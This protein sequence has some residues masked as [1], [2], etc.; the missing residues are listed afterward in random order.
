MKTKHIII[1][2]AFA[3]SAITVAPAS[4]AALSAPLPKFQ[5]Q[6]QLR[7]QLPNAKTSPTSRGSQIRDSEV[8][9]TGKTADSN[10][11]KYIFR[12]RNY[13]PE[14]SRWS[15]VDP[16]GF[17]DGP[18]NQ[19][20]IP[21]PTKQ[22]D[23]YGLWSSSD[24]VWHYF[25][26]KNPYSKGDTVDL[27][28]TNDLG[29]VKSL[30]NSHSGG[31]VAF[32]NEIEMLLLGKLSGRFTGSFVDNLTREVNIDYESEVFALGNSNLRL[33][34]SYAYTGQYTSEGYYSW[35][36]NAQFTYSID[37][38]FVDAVDLL[39]WFPGNQDVPGSQSFGIVGS[40]NSQ[41]QDSGLYE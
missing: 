31:P 1:A 36:Y 28:T 10:L 33:N 16:S 15:A 17:A 8:F 14:L 9:F 18:N 13:D 21:I 3:A 39:D 20:Y 12:F 4:A 5:S 24:Y 41:K 29:S 35:Q 26:G 32:E 22:L 11:A 19:M 37:D 25:F 40:W 30:S 7:S 6:E 2:A 23:A 38:E 34:S 27:S